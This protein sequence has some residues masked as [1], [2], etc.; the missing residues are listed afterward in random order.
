[1]AELAALTINVDALRE[2][3][4][5]DTQWTRDEFIN[6]AKSELGLA[7]ACKDKKDFGWGTAR[8]SAD[9]NGQHLTIERWGEENVIEKLVHHLSYENWTLKRGLK[10][11]D[12]SDMKWKT[13]NVKEA[14]IRREWT[15]DV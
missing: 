9:F 15:A 1:M 6:S 2:L 3:I 8:L 11:R 7:R 13:W 5:V 10:S 12:S 14:P 4:G